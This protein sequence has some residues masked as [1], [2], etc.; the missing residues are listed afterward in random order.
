MCRLY[1]KLNIFKYSQD[2]KNFLSTARQ[3]SILYNSYKRAMFKCADFIKNY[4]FLNI[5]KIKKI[6]YLLTS[7]L[8]ILISKFKL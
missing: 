3:N 6:S 1:K 7:L 4:I 5:R 8:G 2:K